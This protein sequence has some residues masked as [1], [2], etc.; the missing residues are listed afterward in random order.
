MV[1][2]GVAAAADAD[3]IALLHIKKARIFTSNHIGACIWEGL[4]REEDMGTIAARISGEYGVPTSQVEQDVS[5]FLA[6]LEAHGCI[7]DVT[8]S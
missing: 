5:G 7:V 4:I 2:P 8:K 6:D 1:A 3:G